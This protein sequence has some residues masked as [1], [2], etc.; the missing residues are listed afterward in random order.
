MLQC[1]FTSSGLYI[2]TPDDKGPIAVFCDMETDGGGWTVFQRRLDGSVEF[3]LGW[4]DYKTGFGNLTGEF[5]LG[6]D[7]IHRLTAASPQVLRIDMEDFE[8]NKRH[9]QYN[10]FSVADEGTNYRLIV[11]SYNGSAGDSL[12]CKFIYRDCYDVI[13]C[14]IF[15]RVLNKSL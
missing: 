10:S 3:Y 6:N 14:N 15:C 5:W 11:S 13:V 4:D 1:G 2:I 12:L 8:S 7:D 9:A